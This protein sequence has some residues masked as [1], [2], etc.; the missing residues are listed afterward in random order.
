MYSSFLCGVVMDSQL[1]LAR[2]LISRLERLSVDS[3]WAHQASGV[4]RSLLR[5][6]EEA[7]AG[8]PGALQRLDGLVRRGFFIV[9]NAARELGDRP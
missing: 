7:E 5:C 4:R 9:E 1:N 3:Y 6:V 8:Q 2:Q